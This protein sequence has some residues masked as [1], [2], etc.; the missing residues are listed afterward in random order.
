MN[1]AHMIRLLNYYYVSLKTLKKCKLQEDRKMEFESKED[2]MDSDDL[3]LDFKN[4][5]CISNNEDNN[6]FSTFEKYLS[7]YLELTSKDLLSD[8]IQSIDELKNAGD[9][10]IKIEKNCKI[11]LIIFLDYDSEA[12]LFTTKKMIENSKKVSHKLK[13]LDS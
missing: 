12:F 6:E 3:N 7:V 2:Q 1:Y 13:E 8:K 11:F 4:N 9:E 5:C 10:E